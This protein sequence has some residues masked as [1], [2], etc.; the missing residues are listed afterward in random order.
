MQGHVALTTRQILS[1]VVADK[2][3]TKK[4]KAADRR[5]SQQMKGTNPFGNKK[6][7]RRRSTAGKSSTS[8]P[9]KDHPTVAKYVK[10]G[11]SV[12]L[13]VRAIKGGFEN[14]RVAM[15][16]VDKPI[17]TITGVYG[18]QQ[19]WDRKSLKGIGID[20]N[21]TQKTVG[22]IAAIKPVNKGISYVA[23]QLPAD[24]KR[25]KVPLTQIRIAGQ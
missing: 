6:G 11:A 25:L 1:A 15:R 18:V 5:R 23:R 13:V 10:A 7:G 8:S 3:R 14:S 20:L 12:L 24:V 16:G 22:S 9:K 19:A 17:Y 21:A 2:E 4:Q